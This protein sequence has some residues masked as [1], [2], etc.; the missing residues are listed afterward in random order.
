MPAG[1]FKVFKFNDKKIK[2]IQ[3]DFIKKFKEKIIS[4]KSQKLIG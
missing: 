1:T 4:M 2:K 3:K